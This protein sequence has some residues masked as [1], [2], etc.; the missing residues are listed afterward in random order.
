MD[1]RAKELLGFFPEDMVAHEVREFES[2]EEHA[3]RRKNRELLGNRQ[4]AFRSKKFVMLRKD[5]QK[6]SFDVYSTP[7]YDQSG[8]F[9]GYRNMLWLHD[10]SQSS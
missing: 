5:G 10:A 2:P 1:N 6:V 8:E 4:V 3:L 7:F 9:M